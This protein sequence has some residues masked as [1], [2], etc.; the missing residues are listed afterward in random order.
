MYI[1]WG[2]MGYQSLELIEMHL[3]VKFSQKELD[4]YGNDW[5]SKRKNAKNCG[6]FYQNRNPKIRD[7]TRKF[8][9]RKLAWVH[10]SS[11]NSRPI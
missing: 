4:F 3:I 9:F 6:F 2:Q 7:P 11:Q 8:A 10:V 1:Q 5:P